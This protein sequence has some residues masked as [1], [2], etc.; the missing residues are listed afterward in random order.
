MYYKIILLFLQTNYNIIIVT[1]TVRIPKSNILINKAKNFALQQMQEF[2]LTRCNE[3]TNKQ[4]TKLHL[5]NKQRK[6]IQNCQ[7]KKKLPSL[8]LCLSIEILCYY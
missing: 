6:T 8:Y 5:A 3:W 2:N 7:S 1:V 4:T